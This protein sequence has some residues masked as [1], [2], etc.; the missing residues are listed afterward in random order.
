MPRQ[1]LLTP[2]SQ[3]LPNP[4]RD[5]HEI[6]LVNVK[7]ELARKLHL[8]DMIMVEMRR[9]YRALERLRVTKDRT[10]AGLAA[11]G[12]QEM[13]QIKAIGTSVF[14]QFAQI[15]EELSGRALNL[16]R[17]ELSFAGWRPE[18]ENLAE[19]ALKE[20]RQNALQEAQIRSE[21][22]K[23]VKAR[24]EVQN[25]LKTAQDALKEAFAKRGEAWRLFVRRKNEFSDHQS[26]W[27]RRSGQLG[28]R[29][30]IVAVNSRKVA[31]A[32]EELEREREQLDRREK[33]LVDREK[34]VSKKISWLRQNKSML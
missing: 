21:W 12:V 4:P 10:T 19:F 31:A 9:L 16:T 29:E 3:Q 20:K 23:V 25:S 30:R 5:D 33:L 27:V 11:F 17:E 13:A 26:E 34:I 14:A 15:R 22:S 18:A 1:Q 28:E 2:L 7:A 8:V 24:E 6:N 32:A